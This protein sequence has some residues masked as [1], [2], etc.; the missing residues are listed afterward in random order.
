[1]A[2]R[3]RLHRGGRHRHGPGPPDRGRGAALVA[4][5]GIVS[6]LT[7]RIGTSGP[8]VADAQAGHLIVPEVAGTLQAA[9]PGGGYR[10]DADGADTHLIVASLDLRN[11]T[12]ADGSTGEGTPGDGITEY[13]DVAQTL[14]EAGVA[15]IVVAGLG[16]DGPNTGSAELAPTLRVGPHSVAAGGP[17]DTVPIVAF[18]KRHRAVSPED[19]ETW[20]AVAIAP[21]LTDFDA[22]SARAV[23]LIA[24][25]SPDVNDALLP[26]GLDGH[27]YRMT[28]N[29]VAA[30]VAAWIGRN[31]REEVE[32]VP[33]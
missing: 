11:A 2:R 19:A 9:S 29:G 5:T 32:R 26:V 21:T 16:S 27:R 23:A 20:A 18:E 30:P 31:L 22:S 3:R 28:G 17:G 24:G 12:R 15:G 10:V 14:T 1:M 25:S 33:S 7:G 4:E 13:P 6:A 8:D